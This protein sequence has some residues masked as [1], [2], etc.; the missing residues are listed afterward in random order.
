MPTKPEYFDRF[1][2]LIPTHMWDK[3]WFIPIVKNRKIPDV[4]KGENWLDEKFKLNTLQARKRLEEGKNVA[5]V[6]TPETLFVVDLDLYDIK[7]ENIKNELLSIFP[8]TLEIQTPHGGMHKYYIPHDDVRNADGKGKYKGCGEVRANRR[9]V[10]VPG[11]C[12]DGK[13]YEITN[14][15]RPI[16]LKSD[17]IPDEF[18][19]SVE[20]IEIEKQLERSQYEQFKNKYG[21]SLSDIVV[22]DV[23][24]WVLLYKLLPPG[25]PS[26]SEADMATI[27]KLRFWEF[28]ENVIYDIMRTFRKRE[29]VIK[30]DDYL[31]RTYKRAVPQQLISDLVDTNLW[32][33]K[34]QTIQQAII[35]NATR[36]ADPEFK[37]EILPEDSFIRVYVESM[38]ELTDAYPEYHLCASLSLL[39][40]AVDKNVEIY[41][42]PHV[43][44]TNL[45]CLLLGESTI[46]RKT[47]AL[48]L[49]RD[50]LFYA[51]L[52]GR[53]IPEDFSP[54]ALLDFLSRTPHAI[55]LKDEFADFLA[56]MKRS[57]AFGMDALFCALYSNPPSYV[58]KLRKETFTI[59]DPYLCLL[60][61]TVPRSV[62]KMM[63]DEDIDTG[64]LPRFL[65]VMPERFKPRMRIDGLDPNTEQMKAKLGVWLKDIHEALLKSR[66]WNDA[67]VRAI[68]ED[69]ALEM[70]NTF[71]EEKENEFFELSDVDKSRWGAILGRLNENLLKIACLIRVSRKEFLDQM[72]NKPVTFIVTKED[73][74][75]AIKL[76]NE[77]FMNYSFKFMQF[78]ESDAE[79]NI[80]E[81][82]ASIIKREGA[83][84]RSVAL[85]R[86]K[87]RARDFEDALNT[88]RM[89]QD[90]F[91]RQEE[92]AGRKRTMIYWIGGR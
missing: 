30:R 8:P 38:K 59:D 48:N 20:E 76:V 80:V 31:I 24:L 3:L 72:K 64:F 33:P 65:I 22:H 73:M 68:I 36:L 45:W 4:P 34:Y 6:C 39:S 57:Y 77:I 25:Y 60:G 63:K 75:C 7:D 43:Q 18:K 61:A 82:L 62:L 88:L 9:Y 29:K 41:T 74:E 70:Y 71:C 47:T 40:L 5:F 79:H 16:V 12:V 32:N 55:F 84:E 69:E 10:L 50:V 81:K 21:W 86:S 53:R 67:C 2:Q 19:P 28:E 46:S 15:T 14:A 37:I 90:I 92:T 52:E 66:E 51:G 27:S 26:I 78:I 11:S 1:L 56:K 35:D 49:A 13:L 23:K 54:E 42:K 17:A 91:E 58:R 85:K 87:L 89:R 83:I 44:Y